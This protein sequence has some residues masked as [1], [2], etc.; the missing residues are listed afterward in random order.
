M[1]MDID[2]R[3]D[4]TELEKSKPHIIVEVLECEPNYVLTKTIIKKPQ[5]TSPFLLKNE[6][7]H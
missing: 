5:V 2:N 3:F 7:D 4:N 6:Y 1:K